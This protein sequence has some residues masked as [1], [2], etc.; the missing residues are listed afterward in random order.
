MK[1]P[2]SSVSISSEDI[3]GALS[4][5]IRDTSPETSKLRDYITQRF[6]E[7][8]N[9]I[10]GRPNLCELVS[11]GI[12]A[13]NIQLLSEALMERFEKSSNHIADGEVVEDELG[14]I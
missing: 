12:I 14:I 11:R 7:V 8:M 9:F 6:E 2:K 5:I 3:W 1:P 10:E 4:L 13:D